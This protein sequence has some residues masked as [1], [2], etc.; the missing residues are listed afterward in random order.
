MGE[1]RTRPAQVSDAPQIG[2]VGYAAWARGI[3][4]H[5]GPEAHE[6]IDPET[7]ESFA[8]A[9]AG[10]IVVAAKN[11]T[12]LGFAATE[13]G[14]NYISDLWVSPDFE[15]RGVGTKLMSVLEATIAARGYDTV[16]VEVLTKNR[17]A[18][19]LYRHLGYQIVWQET[20]ED[21]LLL[22]PLHKTL[23]RKDV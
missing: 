4:V 20:R 22:V 21:A 14:D 12:I 11:D 8:R 18:L 10:Q 19:S 6:R 13:H 15:G 17:R 3:G 23:L 5:V 9:N 2:L 7:F 1:V 16:E